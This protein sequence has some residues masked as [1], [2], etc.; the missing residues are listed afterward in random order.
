MG[1]LPK[2][3]VSSLLGLVLLGGVALSLPFLLAKEIQSIENKAVLAP[4][5]PFPVTVD[6]KTK[7]IVENADVNALFENTDSPLA[8]AVGSQGG[9]FQKVF[10]WL[11]LGIAQS[12][13]YQSLA[14]VD[15]RFVVI[16]PGMRKEQVANAFGGVLGWT[17]K[18]KQT[19]LT[20]TPYAILPL[21]EGSF[22]PGIYP[23]SIDTTPLMAQLLVND[24][25]STDILDH[26]GPTTAQV[27]PLSTAL[28][29]AS[30]IEREAGGMDD[31]RI[32]SG[33]IWN[34]LF[35]NMPLQVDATL[36]YA[37]ASAL[38]GTSWWPTV[39]PSTD[40]R[41]KSPYNTYLN[42]GLPPTPI[43]SPSVASVLAALN[44]VNTTCLFYFH[45]ANQRFHCSDTYAGHVT[46]LKKYYG[47]GK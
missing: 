33:I 1:R 34:R 35:I 31:R 27:V 36:Q 22:S 7:T 6:P 40:L 46:L 19:F 26:Y 37:K 8:A 15:G 18:E 25:F 30:L 43:A 44:P 20:K 11:A 17:T 12:P 47:R 13:W 5:E 41:R 4:T 45:D 39:V 38:G 42:K 16:T 28:T 32:I 3:I 9:I 21:P 10:E 2:V 23:V 24:R 29:I 14:A